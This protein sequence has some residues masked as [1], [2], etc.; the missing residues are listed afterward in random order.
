MT[1]TKQQIKQ[2]QSICSKEFSD[3]DERLNFLSEFTG[4]QI[5]STKDL[6]ERQAYEAIRFL[7]TGKNPNNSFYALFDKENTQHTTILSLA[8]QLG[9][10]QENKPHLVD[11]KTLG[12]WI[13]S[14]KCPVQKPINQMNSKELS[15]VIFALQQVFEWKYSSPRSSPS[16]SKGG[17]FKK[18]RFK[19]N[20][21][22]GREI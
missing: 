21:T 20:A 16:P 22:K 3:R 9:W 19:N 2:L 4:E 5:N 13:I 17:G 7:N 8:H 12:T 1:I 6:T 10:V 18:G 14:S 15:K 11:L